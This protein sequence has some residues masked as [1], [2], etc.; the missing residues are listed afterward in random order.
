MFPSTCSLPWDFPLIVPRISVGLSSGLWFLCGLAQNPGSIF[1]V[2]PLGL[3]LTAILSWPLLPSEPYPL[4]Y[5]LARTWPAGC[6]ASFG[7][8]LWGHGWTPQL[9][10]RQCLGYSGAIA[11]RNAIIQTGKQNKTKQNNHW[12]SL[13]VRFKSKA[14]WH[15]NSSI[16]ETKNQM[17]SAFVKKEAKEPM[18]IK[19]SALRL[20]F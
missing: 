6:L 9:H 19:F 17:L 3:T 8:G 1:T 5:L 7:A 13:W 15:Q 16:S 11:M 4:L 10:H 12:G 20:F 14:N 18:L 2:C